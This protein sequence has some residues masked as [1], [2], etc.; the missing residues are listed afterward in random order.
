LIGENSELGSLRY[1]LG[2][3]TP[4]SDKCRILVDGVESLTVL[5]LGLIVASALR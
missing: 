5:V 3:V 2:L 4:N 1:H